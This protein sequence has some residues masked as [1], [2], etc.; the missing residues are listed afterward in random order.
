MGARSGPSAPGPR[1]H[2]LHHRPPY[3]AAERG[4]ESQRNTHPILNRLREHRD[5]RADEAFLWSRCGPSH[6]RLPKRVMTNNELDDMVNRGR[7]ARE[8]KKELLGR[9]KKD[10]L[11]GC[12]ASNHL[13]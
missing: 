13:I 5:Y 7:D 12:L 2:T 6:A 8:K 1:R 10:T 9:A 3:S 11:I 4:N